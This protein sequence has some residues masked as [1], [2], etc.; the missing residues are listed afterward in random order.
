[1][2]FTGVAG[3]VLGHLSAEAFNPLGEAPAVRPIRGQH[4][5]AMKVA[6]FQTKIQCMRSQTALMD[7]SAW[8]I[9]QVQQHQPTAR[10]LLDLDNLV[11]ETHG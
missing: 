6:A 11:R 7:L 2:T 1:M 4:A 9:D 5:T 8:W 10:I 3:A